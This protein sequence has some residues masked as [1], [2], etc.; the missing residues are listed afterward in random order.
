MLQSLRDNMKGTLGAIVI[1]FIAVTLLL[2]FGIGVL[3]PSPT[4]GPEVAT[5]NGEPITDFDLQRAIAS[6][7]NQLKQ[8]FGDSLPESFFSAE[9]LR[10]PVL[11]SLINTEVMNQTAKDAGMAV[12]DRQVA[13]IIRDIPQFQVDGKFNQDVY[14]Q[15]VRQNGYTAI[16]YQQQLKEDVVLSQLSNGIAATGFV[17]QKQL[18]QTTKLSQQKRDFYYLTVPLATVITDIE[19]TDEQAMA[20]YEE[21]KNNYQNPEQV[22]IEYLEIQKS[23]IADGI[24]ITEDELKQQYDQEV[25]AFNADIERHAAH[26][27]IEPKDDG[28]DQEKIKEV[29]EKLAAGED[30]ATLAEEYSEDFGS[31]ESGG[32]LG[33]TT[34]D[35]FPPAFE[36]ALAGLAVGEVSAPVKTDAG[37]HIIKLLD[38]RGDTPPT[39]EEDKG[40]IER[41]LKNSLAEEE[42]LVQSQELEDLSYNAS[43]LSE[44]AEKM[45]LQVKTAGPFSRSGGFGIAAQPDVVAEAFSDSVLL[46]GITSPLINIGDGHVVVLRKTNYE[47]SR[48]LTFEEVKAQVVEEVKQNIARDR[49]KDIGS[50]LQAEIAAGKSVEE[51]AKARNYEWNVSLATQRTNPQVRRE[52]LNYVFSLAK[53]GDAPIVSGVSAGNGDYFVVSLFKVADGNFDELETAEKRNLNQRLAG[54]S[55]ESDL[56]AFTQF[57]QTQAKIE[58]K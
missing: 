46:D 44:V 39:F 40:R 54:M 33:Y 30:F 1:G 38:I 53:P 18:Q 21:N 43:K 48:V 41:A 9:S 23:D 37:F 28:S 25:S 47:P 7:Q 27:L 6:R 50:E 14:T 45:G 34:G 51:T 13:Q 20:H 26:I 31:S 19:V 17:T 56:A 35:V 57:A 22:T 32:D 58:R 5:V 10:E 2:S 4:S 16:G 12:S 55:G 8:Q 15:L 29:E 42:F 11:E 24:Q 49:V 52:L 36:Q 3:A